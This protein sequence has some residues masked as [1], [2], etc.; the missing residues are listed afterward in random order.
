MVQKEIQLCP[1]LLAAIFPFQFSSCKT[2]CGKRLE[3]NS[4]ILIAVN[5]LSIL[6]AQVPGVMLLCTALPFPAIDS[7]SRSLPWP[8]L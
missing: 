1:N 4:R 8:A 6:H 3:D 5:K 2:L 7:V